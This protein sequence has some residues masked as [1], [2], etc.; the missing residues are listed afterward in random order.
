LSVYTIFYIFQSETG[1]FAVIQ[2]NIL[3]SHLI[4]RCI[5]D[6]V[7]RKEREANSTPFTDP[8]GE[9]PDHVLPEDHRQNDRQGHNHGYDGH[10]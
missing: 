7:L 2:Y 9:S 6:R 4:F 3:Q 10:R 8:G 1:Y 5:H